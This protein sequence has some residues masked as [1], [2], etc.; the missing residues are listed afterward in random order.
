[1]RRPSRLLF[2]AAA[3]TLALSACGQDE[4]VELEDAA[5]APV[6][7]PAEEPE[8]TDPA[9]PADEPADDE[10]DDADD[11]ADEPAAD[12]TDDVP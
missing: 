1:M 11:D 10:A 2:A 8:A 4:P 7:E 9:P 6:E 3:A 5:D 12:D